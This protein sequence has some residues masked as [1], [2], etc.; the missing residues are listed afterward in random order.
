MGPLATVAPTRSHPCL[1]PPQTYCCEAYNILR[2]SA[3]LLL[4]LMHL[5]AGASIPDI[6][7]DPEKAMLK[8]QV[9]TRRAE[10][11]GAEH[12]RVEGSWAWHL[13]DCTAHRLM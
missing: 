2:K 5:M 9:G 6:R 4:N 7:S 8:L 3:N 1:P 11:C 10:A 13:C 12:A